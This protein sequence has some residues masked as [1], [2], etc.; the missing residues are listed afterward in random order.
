MGTVKIRHY[1][2]DYHTHFWGILPV[3]P[4]PEESIYNPS[5]EQGVKLFYAACGETLPS[6]D[7]KR[8]VFALSLRLAFERFSKW[9]PSAGPM[10]F[11]ANRYERGEC[12]VENALIAWNLIAQSKPGELLPS[13][14]PDV[15]DPN[16]ALA[17][18]EAS[19]EGFEKA[20]L[21]K[22]IGQLPPE[23]VTAFEI[24]LG[25]LI[26]A[27]VLT[28]AEAGEITKILNTPAAPIG[29]LAA[30]CRINMGARFYSIKLLKAPASI[31]RYYDYFNNMMLSANEFTPFDDAYVSRDAVKELSGGAV[32]SKVY[33]QT[34]LIDETNKYYANEGIT[35]TQLSMSRKIKGPI[36]DSFNLP[37]EAPR[38]WGKHNKILYHNTNHN[39][40]S[41]IGELYRFLDQAISDFND[42][43]SEIT[44]RVIGVDF[45][46]SETHVDFATL[47]Q[48][49]ETLNSKLNAPEGKRS[50]VLRIHVGEGS[51]AAAYNR[52][53]FGQMCIGTT[54]AAALAKD[55]PYRAFIDRLVNFR[56]S[57]AREDTPDI[58]PGTAD[59][60]QR[61]FSG[62]SFDLRFNIFSKKTHQRVSAIA[63]NN[64]LLLYHA[65]TLVDDHG[66]Y[67]YG[68]NSI[69]AKTSIRLG[70]GQH[71]RQYIHALS[72]IR[73]LADGFRQITF[74][75]NLGSNYITGS[76]SNIMSPEDY[77]R[78]EG[79]R[80]LTS[81]A[82]A[83]YVMQAINAVFGKTALS[84]SLYQKAFPLL[85]GSDGQGVEHTNLERENIRGLVL[86][87][88]RSALV[89]HN[90]TEKDLLDVDGLLSLGLIDMAQLPDPV[91]TFL[92]DDALKYWERTVGDPGVIPEDTIRVSGGAWIS[93]QRIEPTRAS[94]DGFEYYKAPEFDVSWSKT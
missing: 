45:L 81:F 70:H 23:E 78:A 39:L 34:F 6:L 72:Q 5:L 4:A 29:R 32:D 60:M 61:I 88:L 50:F 20:I 3:H 92:F 59:L 2:F 64:M 26:K 94:Y 16:D 69:F 65:A 40:G 25:S 47:F 90:M 17:R 30:A 38:G 67:V 10:S 44:K 75:T 53:V 58:W 12:F 79:I 56:P 87:V 21:K 82:P 9:F 14:W 77:N 8:R 7:V 24:E 83:R 54:T 91:A 31:Y 85:V 48:V 51:G 80:S 19:L 28:L 22:T 37:S 68:P 27:N 62:P 71:A 57:D 49:M 15:K 86:T 73:G 13:F 35:H 1:P 43:K 76:S 11:Q 55:G 52:S 33:S 36:F 18:I 93:E 66:A 84:D 74:D 46:G 42:D 63:E 41:D 89:S